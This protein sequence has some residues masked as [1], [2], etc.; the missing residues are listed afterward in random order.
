MSSVIYN[1]LNYNRELWLGIP[2]KLPLE[3]IG[4]EIRQ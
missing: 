4:K 3:L 2:N 1:I